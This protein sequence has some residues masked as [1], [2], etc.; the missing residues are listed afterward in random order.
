MAENVAQNM[1]F[2]DALLDALIVGIHQLGLSS[3]QVE[4]CTALRNELLAWKKRGFSEKEGSHLI[5]DLANSRLSVY[6]PTCSYYSCSFCLHK[7]VKMA[8]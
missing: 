8:K 1:S 2:W 7:A 3:W 4:E 6:L 5:S